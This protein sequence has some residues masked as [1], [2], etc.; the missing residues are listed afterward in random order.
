MQ[1]TQVLRGMVFSGGTSCGRPN[2]IGVGNKKALVIGYVRPAIREQVAQAEAWQ[3]KWQHL[4][5]LLPDPLPAV[6]P[7][8]ASHPS[9][10][11]LDWEH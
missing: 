3:L 7:A 9:S 5:A 1:V 4:S 2:F 8:N 11:Y 6:S 10:V